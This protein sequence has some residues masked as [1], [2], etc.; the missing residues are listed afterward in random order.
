[1]EQDIQPTAQ[2]IADQKAL[3]AFLGK[4]M[5]INTLTLMCDQ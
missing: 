1:M 4:T 3:I 5:Y 2:D